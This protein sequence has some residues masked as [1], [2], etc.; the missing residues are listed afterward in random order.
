MAESQLTQFD[1]L[2]R[3]DCRACHR[4]HPSGLWSSKRRTL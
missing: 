2:I 1:K 4:G 3:Q